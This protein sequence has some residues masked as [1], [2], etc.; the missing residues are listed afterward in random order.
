[1]TIRKHLLTLF[2]G[3][4]LLQL[5]AV[6]QTAPAN[7]KPATA[8]N[9]SFVVKVSG[10]GTPMILIPGFSSSGDTWNATAA[11]FQDKYECHVITEVNLLLCAL[12]IA[13]YKN[14]LFLRRFFLF[15]FGLQL[16][17]RLRPD[18]WYFPSIKSI[19]VNQCHQR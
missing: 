5:T 12:C 19:C 7:T 18:A 16:L 3:F 6:A 2:L 9:P 8:A 15:L 10:K 4:L 13:I 1:M 14:L 11:H 17:G